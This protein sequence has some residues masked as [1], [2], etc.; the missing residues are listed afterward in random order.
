MKFSSGV[1]SGVV[2]LLTGNCVNF[3]IFVVIV[4]GICVNFFIVVVLLP[5]NCVN[6]DIF[7]VIVAGIYV[8]ILTTL[9]LS[10]A[11]IIVDVINTYIYD[12]YV[13]IVVIVT[14]VVVLVVAIIEFGTVVIYIF[15][16]VVKGKPLHN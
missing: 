15:I 12:I 4:I 10:Q 8:N 5:G 14:T 16:T 13:L 11:S 2:V 6:F 7:V 3:V 9:S 1:W